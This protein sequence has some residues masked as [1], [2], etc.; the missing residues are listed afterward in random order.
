M[1]CK[2]IEFEAAGSC[3]RKWLKLYQTIRNLASGDL[4]ILLVVI[5]LRVNG[6]KKARV[7]YLLFEVRGQNE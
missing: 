5:Q 1:D 3:T 6:L 2:C 4:E 7:V